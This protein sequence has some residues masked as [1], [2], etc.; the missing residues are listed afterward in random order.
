MSA[1]L[2]N[3]PCRHCGTTVGRAMLAALVI[4]AGGS[5]SNDPIKCWARDDGGDHDFA[6]P[7]EPKL[8]ESAQ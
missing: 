7:D 1:A 2:L 5:C 4:D 8:A 6:L 3:A